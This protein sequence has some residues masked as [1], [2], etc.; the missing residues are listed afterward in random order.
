VKDLAVQSWRGVVLLFAAILLLALLTVVGTLRAQRDADHAVVHSRE[1]LASLDGTLGLL[2]DAE[3]GQR[4]YLLTQQ[5]SYLDPYRLA[6]AN[7]PGQLD[8]LRGLTADDDVQRLAIARLRPDVQAKLAE[9]GETI[10]LT[11]AGQAAAALALVRSGRGATIMAGLRADLGAMRVEELRL[12]QVRTAREAQA[13][14]WALVAVCAMAAL[15]I[16]LLW[17]LRGL[18]LRDAARL[19]ASEQRLATTLASVGDAVITTDATGAVE[20]MNPVAE[21]LGGWH[22]GEAVGVPL[23]TVFHIINEHTRQPVESPHHKVLREGG[24]VGLANHTLLIAKDGAERP[25]EDSGAPIRGADGEISGVVLVFKD[26]TDRYLAERTLAASEARFKAAVAVMEGVLWTNTPQGEMRGEQPGWSALTGQTYEE[27]QGYGWARAVHPQ[28]AQPTVDAWNDAVA[29]RVP[30]RFE[31]RVRRHDGVWRYFSIRSV[32]ILDAAGQITEWVGV[33]TDITAQRAAIRELQEAD[34]R[35]DEFLATL[36]HELR[37][38]LAPIR[39]AARLLKAD[40]P[41]ATQAKARD[42]IERQSAQMARLLDDLLDVSRIT[43]GLVDLR[44]EVLDLREIIEDVV[45]AN[46][47]LI[48]RLHHELVLRVP[49]EPLVIAGDP[50][51]MNQ[52]IGNLIQNAVKYTN[53]SGH[54]QI[55]AA[56]DR[57]AVVLRVTDSGIGIAPES[58]GRVFELFAQVHSPERGRSGLGI[59]LAVVKRIVELHGGTVVALSAGLGHGTCFKVTLPRSTAARPAPAEPVARAAPPLRNARVLLVDD[60]P[61]ILETLA[62]LLRA[63]NYSVHTAEDGVFAVQVAENLCPDIMVI[64]I[65]MPRMDGYQLARWVRQQS[66]GQRAKLIAVTGWGQEVDRRRTADAGFDA[67]LVKP[68]DPDALIRLIDTLST[69]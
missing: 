46:R 8:R 34:Q 1:V 62:I 39:N 18:L 57:D 16:F 14:G 61:D 64:D 42:I 26:A 21:A 65:G 22:S 11:G 27:Y 47:P 13:R 43:R 50:I 45:L 3:T 36:A 63:S 31:H 35:K 48:E 10:S 9:L 4:G 25:I 68:V 38:P 24:I 60:S 54:I 12:L 30:F 55:D 20:R 6:V 53:P 28:D 40:S 33:H 19:R 7:L 66:W 56:L 32:P 58:L 49:P 69:H 41:P 67:H 44:I 37:N 51:R 59:G 52:V 17:G 15:A 23:D 2:A 29:R 5:S